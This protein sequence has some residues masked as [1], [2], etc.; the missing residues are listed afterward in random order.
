MVKIN[1]EGKLQT[2]T[3]HGC[4]TKSIKIGPWEVIH[5]QLDVTNKVQVRYPAR[6]NREGRK[7]KEAN[8]L[9][10]IV[11]FTFQA[12]AFAKLFGKGKNPKNSTFGAGVSFTVIS[13]RQSLAKRV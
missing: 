13:K 2:G 5:L 8:N 6:F 9:V 4:L 10:I 11:I 7:C 3:D 1:K 12:M